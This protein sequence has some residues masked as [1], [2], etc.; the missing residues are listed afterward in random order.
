MSESA[1]RRWIP[2]TILV[3]CEHAGND[4]PPGYERF[5]Q[6]DRAVLDTHRGLD[7][8]ALPVAL[9]M[10][11]AL[12]AP[13]VFSTVTRL[14]IDLNR[15]FDSPRLFSEFVGGASERTK[16]RII[17][18]HYTPHRQSVERAIADAIGAGRRVLH[19][20]VHSCAD[21]L[22]G[23]VRELDLALLFDPVRW[24]EASLCEAWRSALERAS[25]ETRTR[26]NEPYLGTDDGLTTALRT[27]FP[28]D[29]YAG[30][31]IEARQGFI[32]SENTQIAA[33][34]LLV[35]S[36]TDAIRSPPRD[37]RS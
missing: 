21:E 25:P 5:F 10:A 30:I 22:D 4:V 26:F 35:A 8:G 2:D 9:R 3:T 19:I 37:D 28:A 13:L 36:L 24:S 17:D 34:N 20:G 12:S 11:S 33:A 27:E 1:Q 31:E 29:R 6:G 16:Q 23:E 7:P 15:S 32:Q 14:L 18:E